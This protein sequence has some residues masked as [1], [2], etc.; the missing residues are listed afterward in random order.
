[1]IAVLNASFHNIKLNR[2]VVLLNGTKENQIFTYFWCFLLFCSNSLRSANKKPEI[3]FQKWTQKICSPLKKNW[4]SSFILFFF[5]FLNYSS[6]F[7]KVVMG[8]KKR[9]CGKMYYI[10]SA[11][12]TVRSKNYICNVGVKWAFND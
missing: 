9:A 7:D 1:M 4:I 5:F 3:P 2:S 8:E 6:Q 10:S 11:L 12:N